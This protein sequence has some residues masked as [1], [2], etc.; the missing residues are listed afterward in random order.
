[1]TYPEVPKVSLAFLVNTEV[2]RKRKTWLEE[3]GKDIP[4]YLV[5][6]TIKELEKLQIAPDEDET[7]EKTRKRNYG[8]AFIV[9]NVLQGA[10][11]ARNR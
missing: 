8:L 2:A 9:E 1:M 11:G 4:T 3:Q 5:L 10:R 7:E 6:P